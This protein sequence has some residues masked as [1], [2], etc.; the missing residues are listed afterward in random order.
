MKKSVVPATITTT[1]TSTSSKLIGPVP[2]CDVALMWGKEC[3]SLSS[4]SD[5]VLNYFLLWSCSTSSQAAALHLVV[6]VLLYLKLITPFCLFLLFNK[7]MFN[8]I[9]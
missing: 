3:I 9:L 1:T 2:G 8:G 4:F 5:W 7:L 6:T